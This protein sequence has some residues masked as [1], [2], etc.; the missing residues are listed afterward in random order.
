MVDSAAFYAALGRQ[1]QAHRRGRFTQEELASRLEP[2]LTRAA[3]ANIE[4]GKQ[5]V[6]IYTLVQIASHLGVS[7]ADLLPTETRQEQPMS[8]EQLENELLE[9]KVPARASRRL[10]RSLFAA[11]PKRKERA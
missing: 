4:G 9:A 11:A 10:T 6:L 5:G 2:P 7:P 3:I 1:I 8:S